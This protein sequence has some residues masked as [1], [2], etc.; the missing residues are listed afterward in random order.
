MAR[1]APYW[2]VWWTLAVLSALFGVAVAIAEYLGL[3]QELGTVLA[4]VSLGATVLFGLTA[5]TRTAVRALHA[6]LAT[7][8]DHVALRPAMAATLARIERLLDERLPRAQS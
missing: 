5:S 8:A 4:I 2:N 7:V 1:P 3:I 6:N